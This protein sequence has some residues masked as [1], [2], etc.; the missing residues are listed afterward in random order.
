MWEVDV[1]H[2][3]MPFN[4]NVAVKVQ[5]NGGFNDWT[6]YCGIQCFLKVK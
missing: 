3:K 1:D 5:A 2:F 4:R 6:F